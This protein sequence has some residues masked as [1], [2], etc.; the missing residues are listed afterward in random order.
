MTPRRRPITGATGVVAV[1]GDPVRHSLSPTI[2]NAAF[3]ALGLDLVFVAMP[4]PAGAGADAVAAVRLLDLVGLSVTMPHKADVAA[5]VDRCT[6]AAAR[7]GAVNC[8]RREEGELVGDNTDGGGFVDAFG[9]ETGDTFDGAVVAVLGAGGAARAVIDAVATAGAA[10]VLVLNRSPQPATRAAALAP[11]ARVGDWAEVPACD[12]VVN[13]T[14][15]G[16]AGGPAPDRVPLDP[17]LLRPGQVVCDL[18]YQPRLTPLLA[19]AAE[20]GAKPVGG[21][22]M[23]VHQA[24]RAFTGWTGH[25]APVAVMREAVDAIAGQT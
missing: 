6:P 9:Q 18:V 11:V 22:G 16:M 3:D 21:V 5:A 25:P 24:A 20:V 2:H 10:Q 12:V 4:V 19:A 17:S 7:L 1:I 13:A 23:L 15:V 8:V 14:A